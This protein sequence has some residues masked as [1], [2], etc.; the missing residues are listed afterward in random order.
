MWVPNSFVTLLTST[1]EDFAKVRSERDTFRD[2]LAKAN[3]LNDWLRM[4]INTLQMERTALLEKAYN[5]RT[6][7]PQIA[8]TPVMG[9]TNAISMDDLSFEDIG[10]AMAKKLGLPVYGN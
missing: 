10:D 6:P 3:I 4:Q 2:E 9:E 7:A 8:R 1:H 5:I